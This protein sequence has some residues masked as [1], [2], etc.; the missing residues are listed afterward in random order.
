MY[1]SLVYRL[2]EVVLILSVTTRTVERAFSVIN[3]IM[4]HD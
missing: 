2:V 3:I 4:I 1:F